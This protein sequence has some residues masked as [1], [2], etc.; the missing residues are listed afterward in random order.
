VREKYIWRIFLIF[1]TVIWSEGLAFSQWTDYK[2]IFGSDWEKAEAFVSDNE[3]WMKQLSVTYN[4]SYPEAVAIIFPELIRYSSLRDKMEITLLKTL[5]IYHGDDYAD[6]SIG[7]FQMKPSFAESVHKKVPLLRGKL[8]NQFKE[9][10]RYNDIRKYRS[11]VVRDL[12]QPES[13][14]LYLIA[15]IKICETIYN[16]KDM[17]ED[18]RLKFLATAYNYSFQKNFEEVNE[19]IGKRFF[20]TKLVKTE[21]YSYSDI[22]VY[23]YN[24]YLK[25]K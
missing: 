23:W 6:F 3:S 14:F 1:F 7:Q 19:T 2:R 25:N 5:Y 9:R 24:N 15:F 11:S 4:V 8:R 16:L 17:D 10:T 22:S 12:E 21:T 18:H 13:Q 20:Y